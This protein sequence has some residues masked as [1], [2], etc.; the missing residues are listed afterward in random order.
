METQIIEL[1]ENRTELIEQGE[2]HSLFLEANT[3][4]TSLPQIKNEHMIP[5][6]VRDNQTLI[7][8]AEFIESVMEV[9]GWQF[10]SLTVSEPQIR[11]SHPIKGR[12]PEARNKPANELLDHEKTIYYERMAFIVEIEGVTGLVDGQ[13]LN[14]T[15]GGV[16]AYNEDNQGRSK[17]Y[18]E[19]FRF[20]IGFKNMVCTNLCIST[21]GYSGQFQVNSVDQLQSEIKKVI[22]AY[23][24]DHHLD[25]LTC[26]P[27][28]YLSE[29]QFA[30][31]IGRCR[32]YGFLAS[33]E[34]E[35]I[36]NFGLT[37][38]QITKVVESY[39]ID[40]NFSS[41]GDGE[42]NLW[43]L[44]NLFTG[45]NKSSYID[46]FL[47]RG[48]EVQQFVQQLSDGLRSDDFWYLN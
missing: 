40:D 48:L 10:G 6:F 42:I 4:S 24:A 2:N 32:M 31:L 5:V 33:R 17:G 45:A 18:G 29:Q 30:N 21:D 3:E 12:I 41:N 26:L 7:S 46:R 13:T 37:D 20:F 1:Q 34:K 47:E 19:H 9:A 38:T 27:E 8:H 43:R 28:Q 15:I 14:L 36:P 22:T 23:S 11:I 25:L 39:Y 16:K 35:L 44:Y